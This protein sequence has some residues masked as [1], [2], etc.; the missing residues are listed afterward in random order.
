MTMI[1]FILAAVGAGIAI[2][3]L[4]RGVVGLLV[5][6]TDHTTSI[7]LTIVGAVVT[8]AVFFLIWRWARSLRTQ[9]SMKRDFDEQ[10]AE[11]AG[12]VE[13]DEPDEGL[14]PQRT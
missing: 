9:R 2:F 5:I 14:T 13:I 4:P 8:A 10:I 3:T 11:A 12:I 1:W 6:G 7:V